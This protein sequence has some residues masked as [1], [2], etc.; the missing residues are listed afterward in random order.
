MQVH[1]RCASCGRTARI[2]IEKLALAAH[3][4]LT[5]RQPMIGM[6][7]DHTVVVEAQPTHTLEEYSKRAVPLRLVRHVATPHRLPCGGAARAAE[8]SPR[9]AR[10]VDRLLW[11]SEW[12]GVRGLPPS[13]CL[14]RDDRGDRRRPVATP[15]RGG[16][17]VRPMTR[18]E[19]CHQEEWRRAR[20]PSGSRSR[21]VARLC[22]RGW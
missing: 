3:A 8:R 4:V 12:T 1:R 22:A 15:V 18:P 5:N 17:R 14:T 19:A 2:H 7:D 10:A 16:A 6:Q 13:Q 21:G 9:A 11:R 20:Q